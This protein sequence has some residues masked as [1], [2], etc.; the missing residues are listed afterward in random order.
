MTFFNQKQEVM[1]VKLTQFG[2]N[3]LARGAFK[4]VY[5]QFFDD[6]ILYDSS[7]ASFQE[8]QNDS[9]ER[10][11]KETPKLKSMHLTYP[12]QER[13]FFEDQM[14]QAGGD[15]FKTL[16]RTV[17][18]HIQERILLYPLSDKDIA[19]DKAPRF[20]IRSLGATIDS[21]SMTRL[22]GSGILKKEPVLQINP[23]YVIK[24]DRQDVK[25]EEERTII[26][27]ETFSDITSREILFSD[28]SKISIEEEKLIID[29]EEL[30]CFSGLENFYLNIYEVVESDEGE[31]I[32]IKLDTFEQVEKYFSIKTDKDVVEAEVKS[33]K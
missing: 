2:K 32:L 28:N 27:D 15:R 26:N 1:D 18:P 8:H 4:P 33:P 13:Y 12:V 24:E 3:L 17:F 16:K 25:P 23:V 11:L 9:E 10:I 21:T 7:Y 5:Y 29:I 19:T 14:I 22:T 31:D 20:D 30:N 6:D